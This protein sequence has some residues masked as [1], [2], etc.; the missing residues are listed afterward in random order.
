MMSHVRVRG[1]RR[2]KSLPQF[3][4]VHWRGLAQLARSASMC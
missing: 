4:K 2:D 3:V 1:N